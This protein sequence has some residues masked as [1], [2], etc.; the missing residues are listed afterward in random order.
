MVCRV[1]QSFIMKQIEQHILIRRKKD[2]IE[3]ELQM[4]VLVT[5]FVM[6]IMGI[7]LVGLKEDI[8]RKKLE[9]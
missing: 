2:H 4:Q 3:M 6:I 7:E 9:I 5:G 1:R 8:I